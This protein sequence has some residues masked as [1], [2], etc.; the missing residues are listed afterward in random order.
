MGSGTY[1]K[2]YLATNKKDPS[3]K[4]AVKEINIKGVSTDDRQ[5]LQNEISIM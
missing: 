3:I 1:G 2:V 4:F 5:M